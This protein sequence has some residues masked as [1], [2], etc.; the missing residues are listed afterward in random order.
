MP[1]TLKRSVLALAAAFPLTPALAQEAGS[2]NQPTELPPVVVTANP[3]GSSLFDLVAPVSV[4]GGRDLSLRRESTLGETVANLPGVSSTYFGPNASRPTIRGLDADRIRILQNGTGMLD[5]SSLSPDHATTVDPLVVDRIEVVRGPAALLYGGTAV[6]G[7]VNVLDNRIPQETIQGVTGRFEPRFGGADNERSGAAVLEGGNG[8]IAFHADVSTRRTDDLKIPDF[9]RSSRQRALDGPGQ[10]QP[11]G[12]LPNSS[13]SGDGGALGTSLT[14]DKGYLGI[15]YADFNTNYGTVA[16]PN[17]R[18]DLKSSRW[19]AAGEVRELGAFI[20]ALK[21]KYGHTDYRHQELESG[22]VAT[23]FRNKGYETRI[24]ATHAKLGPLTGA[25]GAQLSSV[26]F[27]ALGA[28]ALLPQIGSD[29]EALFLY[30]ETAVGKAKFTFGGRAERAR[31]ASAGG[32]PIDPATGLPRF[33]LPQTRKFSNQSGAAGMLYSLNESL[34]L[35]ANL[36]HTERA[37]TY[38][39]LFSNGPH[40]AT[41]QF[42]IGDATLAKERSNGFDVQLRWRSGQHSVSLGGYYNRFRNYIAVLNSGNTRGMDGELNPV[43][44]DGDGIADGS[45]EEILPEALYRA[46]KAEFRGFEAE[47]R[48]RVYEGTGSLD[49]NLRGDYVR[50]KNRDT[51]EAL[52]RI[53][54]LRLGVGLDYRKGSFGAGLDVSHAFKQN[55]VAANELP[56]DSYTLVNMTLTYRVKAQALNLEA[57]LKG[58]NLL[59][60]EARVHTSFLKDIAPL[61][62]R[63]VLVGVR[64][65]F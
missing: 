62:G 23:T 19:D 25:F 30:E 41:G 7:V 1:L 39:E 3:L 8:R 4:L 42:E 59:D 65:T 47:G 27:S 49:L 26:D 5:I 35:A 12:R 21:F 54:P 18:I 61:P 32:G 57:F 31:V 56:T 10:D 33:G 20:E 11:R 45:G 22:A 14:F 6:G 50:A 51:G 36:S 53:S 16:E 55:R 37:P 52:P 58:N 38:Y 48:F 34:A 43:D 64:G 44:A 2:A 15:S 13:S 46:V 60:E 9:A 17:V 40:A 29:S 24:E 28:E 63:G